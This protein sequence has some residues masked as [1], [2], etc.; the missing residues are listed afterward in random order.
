MRI[1]LLIIL[2]SVTFSC[3]TTQQ[4]TSKSF[5]EEF[6]SQQDFLLKWESASQNSPDS[7]HLE[8]EFLKITTRAQMSD[9]IKIK[10]KQTHFGLGS[11][12]W[13]VYAPVFELHAKCSIGAFIYNDDTHEIDFEI[14]SG[15]ATTRTQLNAQEN[16][17][18]LYC[19]SQG[20][21]FSSTKFLIQSEKWYRLKLILSIGENN[22][23]LIKWYLNDVLLKTLQTTIN[24]ET[25]FGIYH[26]LE[27][28][29][30]MGDFLP[31][32]QNY[33][34]FDSFSYSET[35]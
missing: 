20:N 8:N 3:D 17:L 23:Y 15:S 19:T 18:I 2:L 5:N 7:Y 31:T 11:Y 32:T 22:N 35:S 28:L 25:T 29:N 9:R 4:N 24:K 33:T 21:P 26:S 27:N 16:D 30:F 1:T 34:Y 6:N 14:G 12:N 13:L 10:T